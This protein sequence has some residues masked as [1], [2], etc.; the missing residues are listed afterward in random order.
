MV[1]QRDF[2]DVFKDLWLVAC[3]DWTYLV[4]VQ[5]PKPL[6]DIAA[7]YI[8]SRENDGTIGGATI[9]WSSGTEVEMFGVTFRQYDKPVVSLY[10]RWDD[11]TSI[12]IQTYDEKD[13]ERGIGM[14]FVG[15]KRTEG[16]GIQF[17]RNVLINEETLEVTSADTK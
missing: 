7:E 2:G 4:L 12:E 9:N 3:K 17:I 14:K 8:K 15:M 5:L 1:K 10:G 11:D 6:F 16:K 13:G